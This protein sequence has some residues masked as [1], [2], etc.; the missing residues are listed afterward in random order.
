VCV[1]VARCPVSSLNSLRRLRLR[2]ICPVRLVIIALFSYLGCTGVLMVM[3]H[4]GE[5]WKSDVICLKEK[6]VCLE[7]IV[8]CLQHVFLMECDALSFAAPV[9]GQYWW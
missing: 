3:L 7:E 4:P 5:G 2:D 6:C 8:I 1:A 9:F